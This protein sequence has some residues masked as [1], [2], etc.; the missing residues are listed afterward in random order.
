MWNLWRPNWGYPVMLLSFWRSDRSPASSPLG[1]PFE[2]E[3]LMPDNPTSLAPLWLGSWNN[4]DINA[5]TLDPL[6]DGTYRFMEALGPSS[7]VLT[8]DIPRRSGCSSPISMK[9]PASILLTSFPGTGGRPAPTVMDGVSLW[10]LDDAIFSLIYLNHQV[11]VLFQPSVQAL[12]G[13]E[14]SR[15]LKGSNMQVDNIIWRLQARRGTLGKCG[16]YR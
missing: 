7:S 14:V 15:Q 4:C 8:L 16:W 9:S 1:I 2:L 6:E 12:R 13:Q 11:I 5:E 10:V 3:W